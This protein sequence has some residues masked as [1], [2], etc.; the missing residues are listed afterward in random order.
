MIKTIKKHIW[1]RG[2]ILQN[3]KGIGY[4]KELEMLGQLTII[5]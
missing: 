2:L 3:L 1:W 5:I 4:V